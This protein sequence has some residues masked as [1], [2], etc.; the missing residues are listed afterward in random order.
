MTEQARK[1]MFIVRTANQ[2]GYTV[3]FLTKSSER[4]QDCSSLVNACFASL[5]DL[6]IYRAMPAE[7]LTVSHQVK[8]WRPT[9]AWKRSS[10]IVATTLLMS[11]NFV[12]V[13]YPISETKWHQWN[14]KRPDAAQTHRYLLSWPPLRHNDLV[15]RVQH[16][17]VDEWQLPLGS[18]ITPAITLFCLQKSSIISPHTC[19]T[20][21]FHSAE[22][23]GRTV[24]CHS[25][26]RKLI[27]LVSFF[28]WLRNLFHFLISCRVVMF[29]SCTPGIS[30]RALLSV[31]L[32]EFSL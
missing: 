1:Q 5:S 16:V 7:A 19:Y 13:W 24:V 27:K 21:L 12:R 15:Q 3:P 10:P 18:W 6:T 20:A 26:T 30:P 32:V 25:S 11:I 2:W 22:F 17:A 31:F 28:N 4:S 23:L 9:R 29:T 14:W 8:E